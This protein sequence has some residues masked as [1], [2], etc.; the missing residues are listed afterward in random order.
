MSLFFNEEDDVELVR[1]CSL[2]RYIL[3][4]PSY[5]ADGLT[6]EV[7][8]LMMKFPDKSSVDFQCAIKV[9]SKIDLNCTAVT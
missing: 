7:D 3:N 1:R 9:C 2:D 6:A 8:A 5:S 4:T